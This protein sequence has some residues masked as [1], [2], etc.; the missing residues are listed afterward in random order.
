MGDK[1]KVEIE[2]P[3]RRILIKVIALRS[4]LSLTINIVT[5][6]SFLKNNFCFKGIINGKEGKETKEYGFFLD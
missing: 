1:F 3:R 6:F 4:N 2:F 5:N